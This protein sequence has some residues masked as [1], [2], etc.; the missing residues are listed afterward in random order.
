MLLTKHTLNSFRVTF[1]IAGHG[2]LVNE[3]G[4]SIGACPQGWC[5]VLGCINTKHN[6]IVKDF[7]NI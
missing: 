6:F 2:D 5:V 7:Y 3:D 1:V 4:P